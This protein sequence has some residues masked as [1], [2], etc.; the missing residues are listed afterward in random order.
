MQN[1]RSENALKVMLKGTA[2]LKCE[3]IDMVEELLGETLFTCLEK[4]IR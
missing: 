3:A 1:W 2:L 4:E